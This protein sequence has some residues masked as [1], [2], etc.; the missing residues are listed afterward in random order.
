VKGATGTPRQWLP[1]FVL[2][3]SVWGT[4]FLFLQIAVPT[5]GPIPTAW[6]RVTLAALCLLPIVLWRH[7]GLELIRLYKPMI[8]MG[9]L[10]SGIPF[11]CYSYALQHITTGMASVLN[12][13]TPLFTALI[14]WAWLGERPDLARA[15]G[16]LLGL[17]GIG[18]LTL[19]SPEGLAGGQGWALLACLMAT[20]CYGVASNF[21]QRHL[22]AVPPL[23]SAAGSQA[24]ASLGLLLPA[25]WTWP[26]T[27]PS[28]QAWLALA[29]LAVFCTALAYLW[30]FWLMARIGAARTSTV[31]F[32]VPVVATTLGVVLLDEP[33]S[34]W[35]VGCAALILLGTALSN[36]LLGSRRL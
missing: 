22:H 33:L 10:N 31:I 36:G 14:A 13:T 30:F 6:V 20:T 35:M 18:L 28:L 29:A 27:P 15:M 8:F 21:N 4:S 19:R 16:L 26:A 7:Q 3:G 1:V 11:L 32:L 9:L 23:V 5:M 2:L 34:A 12:A 24:G 17:T 25:Y